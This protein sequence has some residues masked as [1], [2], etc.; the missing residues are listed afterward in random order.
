[1]KASV[2]ADAIH[3]PSIRFFIVWNVKIMPGRYTRSRPGC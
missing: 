1:V 2:S 3:N